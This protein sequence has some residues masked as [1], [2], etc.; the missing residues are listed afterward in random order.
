MMR[1]S[2]VRPPRA[3]PRL[4]EAVHV[5]CRASRYAHGAW[6]QILRAMY[7]QASRQRLCAFMLT[8]QLRRDHG[9]YKHVGHA[10]G[11]AIATLERAQVHS[12]RKAPVGT[13]AC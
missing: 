10:D 2:T 9:L 13:L 1:R 4:G 11:Q 12:Q 6:G 7:I 3:A 5:T 8:Y